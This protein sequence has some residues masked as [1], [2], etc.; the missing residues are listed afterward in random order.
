MKIGSS[1]FMKQYD[2]YLLNHGYQINELVDKAS[3]C[4]IKHMHGQHLSLIHI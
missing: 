4:L 1:Q 3:D 2:E